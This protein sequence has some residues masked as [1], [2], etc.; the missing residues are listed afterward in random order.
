MLFK[1]LK[2]IAKLSKIM[3]MLKRVFQNTEKLKNLQYNLKFFN[4]SFD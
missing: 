4:N 2:K 1:N 3:Q